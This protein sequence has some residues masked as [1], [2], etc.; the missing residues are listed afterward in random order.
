M[1]TLLIRRNTIVSILAVMF[2]IYGLQGIGYTQGKTPTVTPGETHTSLVVKFQITLEDGVDENAYQIQLRQ[3]TPQGKWVSKCV[4]IERGIRN[5]I[6]GDPDVFA[7]AIY[8]SEILFHFGDWSDDTFNITA[9]FTDLEPRVTYEARYRDTNLSFCKKNPPAPDPWSAIAEGTTH[10]VTP[11]RAE[12]VD[13]NLAGIVRKELRLDTKGGHIDFLQIPKASLAKLTELDDVDDPGITDLTGLEHATQL[14]DLDLSDNQISDITPLA[15]LTQLTELELDRNQISDITP[16]T[17]LTE[18]TGLLLWDNQIED[19]SSLAGLPSLNYLSLSSNQISDVTLLTTFASLENL[20]HILLGGNPITDVSPVRKIKRENPNLRISIDIPV[21]LTDPG[22][23]PDLYVLA[24][25]YSIFQLNLNEIKVQEMGPKSFRHSDIAIDVAG[26]KIYWATRDDIQRSNL[27]GTHVQVVIPGLDEPEDIA[28]DVSGG[29]VYWTIE[30]GDRIQRANLNGTNVQD[31]VTGLHSPY[32]IALDV[33]GS[34]IYWMEEDDHRIRRANLDGTNVQDVVPGLDEPEDIAIDVSEGMIYWTEG[35]NRR[36]Q[37]ANLDG[38]DAHIIVPDLDG[39]PRGIAL[40]IAGNRI[41]WADY[42]NSVIWRANL[43]GSDVQAVSIGVYN[44]TAIAVHSGRV[45]V[46]ATP[47]TAITDATV[48]ISPTSVASPA[49]GQQLELSLEIRG[50]EAVAGYQATVQFDRTALRYI[51]STNGDY[52]PAGAFFVEPKVEGNLVKLNAASAGESNGAGTLATL[53][54]EVIAV[55]AS[56]LTL[57]DVLLSNSAGETFVPQIE[58]AQITESTGLKGDV[59]ADN[60]VNIADLVLVASNLGKTGQNTA[61]VNGDGQV[62][63]ADL[64]LVAGALGTSAAAPSLH[65]HL[66]Q[67]FTAGDVHQWLS[68][69]QRLGLADATTERGIRYLEQLLSVLT[70]K[71]TVLL[72]NYPNPFNPET[73]IPYQLAKSADVSITIYAVNGEMVRQLS[74]GHQ[75]AGTYQRRDR[76]AYWDGRNALGESVASGVYFYTLTAG[77]FTATRKM[78]IRK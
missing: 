24:D 49:V 65:P 72:P 55:K 62:N 64:V 22:S 33:S 61:D 51:S 17:N 45:N 39:A 8:V 3:Q 34:K 27:D 31:V 70:P 29:K 23:G 78:L 32:G 68:Q 6:A 2:L 48:N 63:I 13:T 52:L 66:F 14:T 36:I 41:Y 9:I 69:A 67:M 15:Q 28:I 30:R 35:G 25:G 59:N 38:T 21:I 20:R 77:D 40:D 46:Q 5:E 18:L 37:R 42:S 57:S 60:T 74:L 7:S 4:V 73:W 75:L 12:F 58:N 43:D 19:I 47:M 53:I 10:L 56:T 11:P 26:E 16:L 1:K 54:F 71:E 44:L 50:G 76:A